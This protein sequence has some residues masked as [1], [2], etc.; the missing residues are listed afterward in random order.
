ME[1]FGAQMMAKLSAVKKPFN[2]EEVIAYIDETC[3]RQRILLLVFEIAANSDCDCD[4]CVQVMAVYNEELAKAKA[5]YE[6]PEGK[7]N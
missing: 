5:L 2:R 1:P 4:N 6:K 7:L 3:L